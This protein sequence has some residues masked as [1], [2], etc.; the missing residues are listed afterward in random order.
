MSGRADGGLRA[1]EV[2]SPFHLDEMRP[3]CAIQREPVSSEDSRCYARVEEQVDIR[4]SAAE[5]H[6]AGVFAKSGRELLPPDP[7]QL[8][9]PGTRISRRRN[10]ARAGDGSAKSA[11]HFPRGAAAEPCASKNST[12]DELTDC[13]PR[14]NLLLTTTNMA[15]KT[16][17]VPETFLVHGMSIAPARPAGCA[18][19]RLR[20]C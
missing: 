4:R 8:M 13:R 18:S 9:R 11:L 1:G 17:I 20:S 14:L 3:S 15:D 6:A 2:H 19:T 12:A 7:P 10:S 16:A 5:A